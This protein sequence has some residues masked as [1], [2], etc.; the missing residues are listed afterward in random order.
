[1]LGDLA[2]ADTSRCDTARIPLGSASGIEPCLDDADL[3]MFGKSHS[4]IS[5]NAASEDA[6]TGRRRRFG[7]LTGEASSAGAGIV[8]SGSLTTCGLLPGSFSTSS[9]SGSTTSSGLTAPGRLPAKRCDM[10]SCEA[11]ALGVVAA[12]DVVKPGTFGSVGGA[13]GGGGCR[14]EPPPD[15]IVLS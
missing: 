11:V 9:A 14:G 8:C 3:G 6:T 2:G 7:L 12:G 10:S 4:S 15:L 13:G 1:M 5:R